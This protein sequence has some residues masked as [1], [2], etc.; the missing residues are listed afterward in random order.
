MSYS[1]SIAAYGALLVSL[2]SDGFTDASPPSRDEQKILARSSMD[3]LWK[4]IED[5][6]SGTV[7]IVKTY[8]TPDEQYLETHQ[9]LFAFEH[10]NGRVRFDNVLT[11][12]QKD[13]VLSTKHIQYARGGE[14]VL[15]HDRLLHRPNF[16]TRHPRDWKVRVQ[17]AWPP[18]LRLIG[19]AGGGSYRSRRSFDVFRNLYED[20]TARFLVECVR[21]N[22]AVIR[23]VWESPGGTQMRIQLRRTLRLDASLGYRPVSMKLERRDSDEAPWTVAETIAT[24]WEQKSECYVPMHCSMTG[25]YGDTTQHWELEFDWTAV[26][27]AIEPKLL[28]IDGFDLPPGTKVFNR[29]GGQPVLERIIGEPMP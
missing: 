2:F 27:T 29:K 23:L 15:L 25:T 3:S 26:N 24:R 21:E 1:R 6:Q 4:S 20:L 9:M 10:Q 22:D 16:I 5:L 8:A 7:R 13:E 19:L 18:E 17:H 14:E 11:V 12:T 28:E